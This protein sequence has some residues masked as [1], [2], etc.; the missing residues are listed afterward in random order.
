M[1]LNRSTQ[2]LTITDLRGLGTSSVLRGKRNQARNRATI[3][4]SIAVIAA[5]ALLAAAN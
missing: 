1:R 4:I 3:A 5:G 2:P